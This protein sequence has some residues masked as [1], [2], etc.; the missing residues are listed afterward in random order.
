[1]ADPIHETYTINLH[2]PKDLPAIGHGSSGQVYAVNE[3]IV[4]KALTIIVDPGP[5]A[6]YRDQDYYASETLFHASLLKDERT[7]YRPLLRWPHVNLPEAVDAERGEGIY[8]R[9]YLSLS[10]LGPVTQEERIEWY[11]DV[12]RGLEH[13]HRFGIAHADLRVD[14][15]LFSS[16]ED[17]EKRHKA[18]VIDFS[19]SSPFGLLNV[20][21]RPQDPSFSIPLNGPFKVLSDGSDRFAMASL[22]FQWETGQK[23]GFS[24]DE[25]GALVVPEMRTGDD[26]LDG[27]IRKGW[28]G[29]YG[30]TK[31]MLKDV[32]H[33]LQT[34]GE[35]RHEEI[36]RLDEHEK[37]ELKEFVRVWREERVRNYG[38]V[39]Y[40]P[41]TLEY[42]QTLADRFGLEVDG[43]ERFR[44]YAVPPAMLVE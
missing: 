5:S 32:E 22:M 44:G 41:P 40:P 2:F 31:E 37:E 16:P 35:R 7:V 29:E 24:T 28:S 18:I 23:P 20:P 14:N 30:G 8:L 19:A 39:T 13:L 33:L 43:E 42:L 4:L 25:K 17:K 15:V 6:S 1:M 3:H 34:R 26:G 12:L 10:A 21:Y 38:S 27:F 9:R 36:G 11:Y